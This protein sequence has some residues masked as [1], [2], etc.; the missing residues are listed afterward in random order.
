MKKVLKMANVLHIKNSKSKSYKH[1]KQ[2]RLGK[3]CIYYN[4]EKQTCNNKSSLTYNAFCKSDNCKYYKEKKVKKDVY[5]RQQ[6]ILP[7]IRNISV[8]ICTSFAI[9]KQDFF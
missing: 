1:K 5:K 7:F 6:C 8:K 2:G 9:I 3:D 4:K